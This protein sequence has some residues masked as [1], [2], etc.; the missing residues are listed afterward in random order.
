[1]LRLTRILTILIIM[2]VSSF[3]FAG[4]VNLNTADAQSIATNLNGVGMVKA[5]A[6]VA[7][8]EQHGSF[9]SMDELLQVKGIGIKTLDRNRDM[10]SLE[11]SSKTK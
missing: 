3:T 9:S 1:M 10:I 5:E 4:P 6:I 2:M 11:A 8:R 7:Y